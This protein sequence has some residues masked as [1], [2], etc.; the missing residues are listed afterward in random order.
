M[1]D[2]DFFK[3]DDD[4]TCDDEDSVNSFTIKVSATSDNEYKT[5][6]S[7]LEIER[8]LY[9]NELMLVR[10]EQAE[11]N[12]DA[13]RKEKERNEERL[14]NENEKLLRENEAIELQNK[15]KISCLEKALKKKTEMLIAALKEKG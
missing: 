5:S 8:I 4:L 3:D 7:D 11:L 1:I 2:D 15:H 14:R 12:E 10:L 9:Q 13:I 6:K